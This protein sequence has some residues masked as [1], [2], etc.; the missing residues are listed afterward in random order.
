MLPSL[1]IA[2]IKFKNKFFS[3]LIRFYRLTRWELDNLNV[4]E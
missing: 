1:G 2:F 4:K 3:I